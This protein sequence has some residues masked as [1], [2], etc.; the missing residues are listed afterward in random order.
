MFD[1]RLQFGL[2]LICGCLAIFVNETGS[3]VLAAI[4]ILL[5]ACQNQYRLG[6]NWFLM[7]CG[8]LLARYLITN[9]LSDTFLNVFLLML[10]IALKTLPTIIIASG[11]AK[12]PS[13]KLIASLQKLKVPESIL[14]TF[15]VALRFFPILRAESKIIGENAMIRGISFKQAKNWLHPLQMFEHSMIPLLMRTIRL[16]DDL[17][18]SATTRGIDAPCKKTSHYEIAFQP[19]DAVGLAAGLGMLSTLWIV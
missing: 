9:Y 5:L 12:V 6:I 2:L 7:Y 11:L 13:G 3:L 14:L 4:A 15:T 8:L 18:A 1:V 10:L 17:S 16:A 19:K